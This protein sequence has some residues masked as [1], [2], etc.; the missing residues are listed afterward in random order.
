MG[1]DPDLTEAAVRR[2][3]RSQSFER[4][5]HYYEQDAVIDCRDEF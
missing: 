2:L 1:Q 3:A 4:G 5:E